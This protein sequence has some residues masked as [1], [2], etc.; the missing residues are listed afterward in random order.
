MAQYLTSSL[1]MITDN[2]MH[3]WESPYI[4][5]EAELAVGCVQESHGEPY[6][7]WPSTEQLGSENIKD[8]N[9]RF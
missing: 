4:R 2:K 3:C 5:E 6:I 7:L 9:Q 1:L 8:W